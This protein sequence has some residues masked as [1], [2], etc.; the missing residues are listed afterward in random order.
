[1]KTN[2]KYKTQRSD[3]QQLTQLFEGFN[4][5]YKDKFL[6]LTVNQTKTDKQ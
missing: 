3:L 4:K 6:L 1:M 2:K 5:V